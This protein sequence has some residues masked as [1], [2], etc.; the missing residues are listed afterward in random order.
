M[1]TDTIWKKCPYCGEVTQHKKHSITGAYVC[2]ENHEKTKIAL[3]RI[4]KGED[5]KKKPKG[6][7]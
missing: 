6:R 1:P 3:D 2:V 5:L 7:K 4:N